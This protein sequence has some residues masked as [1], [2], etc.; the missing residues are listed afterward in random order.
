MIDLSTNNSTILAIFDLDDTLLANSPKPTHFTKKDWWYHP[1]SYDDV[2]PLYIDTKWNLELIKQARTLANIYPTI[3]CT[4]RPATPE[5]IKRINEIVLMMKIPFIHV[6]LK[7]L[8]FQKSTA[9]YKAKTI[10]NW[11]KQ[12]PKLEQVRFWDDNNDNLEHVYKV[13]T[14]NS[15]KV[16]INKVII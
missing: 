12:M 11:A 9:E 7:P 4:G 2:G 13:L 6:Q 5:L 8:T 16:Q 14:D 3:I 10:L 1:R 15:F